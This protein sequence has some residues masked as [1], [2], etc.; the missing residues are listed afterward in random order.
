MRMSSFLLSLA[1][2]AGFA[3]AAQGEKV[4]CI[5]FCQVSSDDM[6]IASDAV[7][8][9][10]V[11]TIPGRAWA[12]SMQ[13]GA[14]SAYTFS[15]TKECVITDGSGAAQDLA[16]AFSVSEYMVNMANHGQITTTSGSNMSPVLKSWLGFKN[17]GDLTKK[18]SQVVVSNIPYATYDAI[19][20]MSGYTSTH[21]CSGVTQSQVQGTDFPAVTVNETAY[22]YSNG[23]TIAGSGSWGQRGNDAIAVGTNALRINGLSGNLTLDLSA[24]DF[25][26]AGILI[27]ERGTTQVTREVAADAEVSWSD[28]NWTVGGDDNESFSPVAGGIYNV[29]VTV[30]GDCTIAMPASIGSFDA[31]SVNFALAENVPSANVTLKYI[32]TLST[33][34]ATTANINPFG[35]ATVTA[36]EGVA[37]TPVYDG[38]TTGYVTSASGAA[39]LAA[40]RPS[41]GVVSVRIGARTQNASGGYIDPAYSAVGPYPMSGLFW[42][43]TKF[44]NDNSTSGNYTDI[45]NLTDAKDDSNTIR[46]GYY[47]HNTYYNS[48]ANDV[49]SPNQVLTK[50]YLDDSSSGDDALTATASSGDETITLPSPG[51]TRGW[52]LHF[53]NIPYNAYDVYFITAS[54]VEN[55]SLKE[56]PIYV[57]LDGGTNWKS[58][59]GDS[60]NERTVMGTAAWTGLPFAQDGALVEGKNYLKMRI[61]KS[62]YGDD[63]D[64]IDITHGRRDTSKNIRSGLAAIQI[65]E[66]KNDGVYTL[67]Q[68]GNWSDAVW[69]VGDLSGQKW[70]DAVDGTAS[71]AKIAS[72]ET[73]S[74]VTVDQN[75]SAGS[76]ILTGSSDFTVAGDKTLTVGTAFDASDFAGA[77]NLQAPIQGT[78]YIGANTSLEFG[79]DTDMSLPGYTIDGAGAWTKVGSGVLTINSSFALPGMVTAGILEIASSYAGNLAL[80]GGSLRFSGPTGDGAAEV[81]FSGAAT[82]AENAS[83]L[84]T[85]ASGVVQSRGSIATD[86]AVLTG[87][88]LKL[89]SQSGFGGSGSAPSGKT[90]TVK[91][92]GVIELNGVEGCNAYT[93]DGGTLQ[94][95]GEA[96]TT[97]SRQT[98][99]LTLTTNSTVHAG[100]DFGLLNNGYGATTLNLGGHTLK[101]TGDAK[102]WLYNTR[103][104]QGGAIEIQ[105]GSVYAYSTVSLPNVAFNIAGGAELKV[106]TGNFTVGELSGTGTVDVGTYRPTSALNF[107]NG[108]ALEVKI[109]LTSTTE[110]LIEI[111][112]HGNT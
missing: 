24:A 15:G 88:K 8:A 106:R 52:Q 26:I 67:T 108:S 77:L 3:S 86:I 92:G 93:L 85:V 65:V 62:L 63:I 42:E 99:S 27:I 1:A 6:R 72:S 53:E 75:V 18:S 61:T 101:K 68:G 107:A 110:S 109:V 104:E 32:G 66:V 73:V 103:S 78:I 58:Y 79:G 47:G 16:S 83:S 39:F 45:Q 9:T 91:E 71:I 19:V 11:G 31:C 36:G 50:T 20:I 40:K 4:I 98:M 57:S 30:G 12:Q 2:V 84:T 41:I 59:V 38:D 37:L 97:E 96:I 25:G 56:C 23:T 43:Q 46:I 44:W 48:S 55:G 64:T 54:D 33:D 28:P 74:S 90:I 60:E 35:A 10:P 49:S 105:A 87:A 21:Y 112:L 80:N 13:N 102:F 81:I 29:T 100:S 17:P 5:N 82:L 95:T 69:N 111:P 7:V 76:V 70:T 51:H 89:G 14:T 94:N 34:S 22:T